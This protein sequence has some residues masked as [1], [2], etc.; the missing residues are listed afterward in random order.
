MTNS[1]NE[2]DKRLTDLLRDAAAGRF[3]AGFEHRV[4]RRLAGDGPFA[5]SLFRSFRWIA[6][7]AAAACLV[8][9]VSNVV[10]TDMESTTV[11]EA[12]FGLLPV[13]GDLALYL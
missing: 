5:E 6:V 11:V 1:H 10:L 9:A 13:I 2:R 3:D 8:L 7:P 4:M 12:M